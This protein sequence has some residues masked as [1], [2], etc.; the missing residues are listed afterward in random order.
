M[1]HMSEIIA[2]GSAN[3]QKLKTKL[4]ELFELDKADLDFGIYRILRQRHREITE[5]LDKHLQRTVHEA[6]QAHGGLQTAQLQDELKNAQ[7][8]AKQAGFDPKDSPKVQEIQAKL[9][10]GPDL[11][12]IADEV[13]SHLYTFF[14]RYYKEGDFIGLHRSTVHGRE[15]Y[16][17]PYNGEEVK[18]VWANMDQ[19]YIKSSELLR[20]YTFR[21]RKADFTGQTELNLDDAPAE[22]II[23]F[24]LV[25]GDTEKDNQ[26]P[27]GQTERRFS[28]DQ[29]SPFE[30][31]GDELFVR[32]RYREFPKDR[33]LQD[34]LNAEAISV[35]RDSLPDKWTM[36]L[37][38]FDPE[39][40]A[41]DKK[42]ARTVLQKHLR[43]YTARHQFDYFIHKDLGGFLRRELDFYLKNEV[44]HLD[45]IEDASS[46]KAE[47]YLSKLRA[48]RR[49]ALPVIRMLAQL[50]E[51]QKKLWLKKKFVVETRYCITLDR[52]PE[53]LYEEICNNDAQWQE[54]EHLYTISTISN[55]L[56]PATRRTPAYL[57]AQPFMVLDTRHFSLEFV[58]KLLRSLHDLDESLGGVCF[59]SENFHALRLM[60][61]SYSGRVRTVYIDPPYNTD[62][63]PI[64][65]KNGYR[66]SSWTT[67]LADRLH[68]ALPLF[69]DG[70]IACV[71]IDDYQ[72]HEL[73]AVLTDLFGSESQLGVAVIRN[74]PSGRSTVSGFS[75]CHEYAYFCK[76]A[77]DAILG[78]F[79][80]SDKQLER[81]SEESGTYVD[82]RNFRKDGG[83]VT[84]RSQRP[85]QFYPVYVHAQK[86]TIRIPEL[87]WDK[88]KREWL[89]LD[90]PRSDEVVVLPI[91]EKGKERVWSLN[92]LSA[93]EQ[94]ANLQVR[95]S[96]DKKLQ[97][98][99][100]HFPSEGVLPRS[101]WDKN[102]YAAR[103]YG[104]AALTALF[105]ETGKFSF[106]KSPHAVQ[107]CIWVAGLHENEPHTVLDFFAGSGT[108][109]HAA[110]NLNRADDGKRTYLLVDFGD[111]F[112]DT[113]VARIKKLVYAPEWKNGRPESIQSGI[114][115]AFKVVRLESYEDT[116]NNLHLQQMPVQESSLQKAAEE[117]RDEYM[118]GY[119]LN[120]E[121][122]QSPGLLDLNQFRDPFSYK[123]EIA[124]HSAGETVPTTV[125]LLET[126]NWL[127]GLTVKQIDEQK[128]FVI[129]TGEKRSGGRTLII[130]R[131]LADDLV[132]DNEQL[133][134]LLAKLAVSPADTEYDFIY[135]NGSHTLN[136]PH[137]K[138]HLTEEAFKRLMFETESFSSLET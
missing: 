113:L 77:S 40:A 93:A 126:F 7:E 69:D 56:V 83:M 52:V 33:N 124:T 31:V 102:T 107:D 3:F 73:A 62:A 2:P 123:L 48:I 12:A 101:I 26:K 36:I 96:N 108:T 42:E 66:S 43:R 1:Q 57:K 32:F 8:A 30:E 86:N 51:F 133:E 109:A 104:T 92:H 90:L 64:A 118:L 97:I 10:A 18:L 45:D 85:K 136:D 72:V 78:R 41:K 95:L 28:L 87:S 38:A 129:V 37:F 137:K 70:G 74:N 99:R 116:L 134:K 105:G 76:A 55:D 25:E 120:L 65:Y 122:E 23:H 119:F 128:G 110:L 20:D 21:I 13:Y 111:Y 114:S 24:K 125:D 60:Q 127:L 94:I 61:S 44:M 46:S 81:F 5:F 115:H 58:R 79:P 112:E 121:S 117:Q 100:R 131:R 67:L 29:D 39:D 80:R 84:H 91:D 54:W 135:I 138:V 14:S 4:R 17:I 89:V 82:W 106:A 132:A 50:E 15:K 49:C 6:L 16:M 59:S 103:E 19:Y 9:G 88:T 130:W 27:S 75:V 22:A 98:L 34:K 35:I 11:E 71:T 63:G 53:S 47:E 68:Q